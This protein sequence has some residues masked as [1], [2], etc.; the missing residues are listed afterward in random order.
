MTVWSTDRLGNVFNPHT[1]GCCGVEIL[2]GPPSCHQEVFIIQSLNCNRNSWIET[3][4]HYLFSVR[5]IPN[6]F[7]VI[8]TYRTDYEGSALPWP[9]WVARITNVR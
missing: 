7:E 9:P 8:H 2:M 6:T 4:S 3:S 1:S 5:L